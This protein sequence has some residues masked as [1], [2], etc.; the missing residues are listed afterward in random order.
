MYIFTTLYSYKRKE[1]DCEM[2]LIKPYKIIE[3]T[4][5]KIVWT[6]SAN[7]KV[8]NLFGY[9]VGTD[10]EKH[11]WFSCCRILNS[12]DSR[13]INEYIDDSL[14]IIKDLSDNK[15]VSIVDS[16]KDVKMIEILRM[17]EING[18]LAD[19]DFDKLY[20]AVKTGL[21]TIRFGF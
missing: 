3:Y 14:D 13:T 6:D 21:R 5:D 12:L 11:I 9:E 16:I 20:K 17:C 7:N 15:L 10:K 19:I 18:L 4:K 8:D 2:V 1:W